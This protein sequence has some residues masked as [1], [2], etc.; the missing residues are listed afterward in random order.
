MDTYEKVETVQAEQW[1]KLGDVKEA[2]VK[3]YEQ[4]NDGW[5]RASGSVGDSQLSG[6]G[7]RV[8]QGDYILKAYD[9]RSDS[10]VYYPVSKEEFEDVARCTLA[11][12]QYVKPKHIR[13]FRIAMQVKDRR[14]SFT[15]LLGGTSGAGKS[16]LASLLATRLGVSAVHSTDA[17]RQVLRNFVPK[18]EEPSLHVR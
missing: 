17:I 10:T 13:G 4:T 9:I 11:A 8:R 14:R 15:I 1:N 12:G 5:I 2:D 16:T 3:K 7:N 18:E 6:L